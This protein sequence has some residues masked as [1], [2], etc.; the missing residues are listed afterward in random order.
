MMGGRVVARAVTEVEEAEVKQEAMVEVGKAEEMV[1]VAKAGQAAE[2]AAEVKME[3]A[4]HTLRGVQVGVVA[5]V[6]A[7]MVVVAG[8]KEEAKALVRGVEGAAAVQVVAAAEAQAALM[9]LGY[10]L[11]RL[12]RPHSSP[13]PLQKEGR[14][15]Q[16]VPCSLQRRHLLASLLA[17]SQQSSEAK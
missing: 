2:W 5:A 11:G 12:P 15:Q 16:L 3:V 10:L 14:L 7:T 13:L 1:A 17:R 8:V 4:A 6:A 9:P